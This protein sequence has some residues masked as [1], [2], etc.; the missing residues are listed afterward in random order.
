MSLKTR[1]D[2]SAPAAR[3]WAGCPRTGRSSPQS[4]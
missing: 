2:I 1:R 4:A 3:D